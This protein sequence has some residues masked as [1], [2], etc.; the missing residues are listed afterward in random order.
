MDLKMY[1]KHANPEKL[2]G[3]DLAFLRAQANKFIKT[4]EPQKFHVG[5]TM[6]MLLNHI[7]YMTLEEMK[8]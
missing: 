7:D 5:T 8:K 1:A 4:G 3:K 2:T 6:L